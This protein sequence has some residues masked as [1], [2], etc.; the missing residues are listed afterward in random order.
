M[1]C[2][3]LV[4]YEHILVGMVISPCGEERAVMMVI[5]IDAEVVLQVFYV[6]LLGIL[7]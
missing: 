6:M 1:A 2:A 5:H 4:G 7:R 3:P